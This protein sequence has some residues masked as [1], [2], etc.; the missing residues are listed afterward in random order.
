M[1]QRRRLLRCDN[2]RYRPDTHYRLQIAE[3]VVELLE[4]F[5]SPDTFSRSSSASH[6]GFSTFSDKRARSVS[7]ART[8]FRTTSET[9][10]S[11][12][13]S[14][15]YFREIYGKCGNRAR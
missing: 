13:W 14:E 7:S 15:T 10:C 8:S 1:A 9:A 2:P 5:N 4:S 12:V 11:F 6:F 3:A